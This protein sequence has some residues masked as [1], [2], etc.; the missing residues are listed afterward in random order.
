MKTPSLQISM[1]TVLI[2]SCL[3]LSICPVHGQDRSIASEREELTFA[4]GSWYNAEVRSVF[5]HLAEVSGIDF[6]LDPG[7]SGKVTLSVTNK[8]WKEIMDILCKM[9]QLIAIPEENY[10]YVMTDKDYLAQLQNKEIGKRNLED[11]QDLEREIIKLSNTTAQ[12]ML[13]PIK[14]LLSKRGKIT[15]VNHNNSLIIYDTPE[16]IS[17]IK[18]MIA[19]LDV[20]V[21]QISISAK[22]IEVSSGTI[23]NLGIQWN[24]FNNDQTAGLEHLPGTDVVPGALERATFSVMNQVQF[25]A[26]LEYLFSESKSDVVAQPQITTVDNKMAKIFMGSQIPVTYQDEAGNTLV[27]MINAGTELTVTPH[28]TSE[29]RIM[30]DLKPTKQSYQLSATGVPVINEQSAM[31]NV[32]VNDGETVVIAGL[33]SNE[34][35][36][37]EEGIPVLK[38]IPLLGHLF[39]RTGKQIDKKDLIIFVTPHIVKRDISSYPNTEMQGAVVR[40]TLTIPSE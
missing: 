30:L 36:D 15:V 17:Q 32:V 2:V 24:L 16:N 22:I 40:D 33:T 31:T 13:T 1:S 21:K 38:D 7:V 8:N 34:K 39:K 37:S 5:N 6:V 23:N 4:K 10:I 26:T 12:E 28:V 20:E 9:K 27:K 18:A 19:K 14:D 25:S 3:L 11:V 29:G 35:H